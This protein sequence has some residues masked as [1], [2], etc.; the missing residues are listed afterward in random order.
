MI[1]PPKLHDEAR[2]RLETLTEYESL[3]SG[4]QIAMRDMELRG[5]GTLLGTKQSGIINS[6]GFNYYNR[7]LERAIKNIQE[8]KPKELWLEEDRQQFHRIKLESDY[9]FPKE[10]ISNEKERLEIYRKMLDFQKLDEF[11]LL[12]NE[13]IDR[14]GKIPELAKNTLLY[15]KL[16]LLTKNSTL[17]SADLKKTRFVIEFDNKRL[18][19]KELIAKLIKK[20]NYPVAFDTTRNLKILFQVAE[21]SKILQEKFV[22]KCLE[23]LDFLAKNQK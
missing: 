9:Y 12:E 3:G 19:S 16:R 8:E 23:I 7:L 1:I 17:E 21:N 14:F 10:Y 11:E 15:Y 5:A 13:L 4:Y 22:E 20:F 6:I 18:P 2:K